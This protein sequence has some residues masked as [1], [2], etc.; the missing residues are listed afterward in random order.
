MD[1]TFAN[2]QGMHGMSKGQLDVCEKAM[3]MVRLVMLLETPIPFF[4]GAT[5]ALDSLPVRKYKK[6]QP[7][8][9]YLAWKW[10]NIPGPLECMLQSG[11]CSAISTCLKIA[12][13]FPHNSI[14]CLFPCWKCIH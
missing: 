9:A 1:N 11:F 3:V 7:P 5:N 2:E 14:G 13:L 8:H 6:P 4:I 10:K 12:I